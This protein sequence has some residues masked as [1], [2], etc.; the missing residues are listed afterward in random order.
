MAIQGV[1]LNARS[2]A[3]NLHIPTATCKAAQIAA[4]GGAGAHAYVN[5]YRLGSALDPFASRCPLGMTIAS[6][7]IFLVAIGVP[8]ALACWYPLPF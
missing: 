4:P 7:I 5:R 6:T 1:C 2:I 8:L 3:T